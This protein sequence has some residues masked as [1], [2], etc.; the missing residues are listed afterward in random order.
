LIAPESAPKN[1][2]DKIKQLAAKLVLLPYQEVWDIVM[3]AE[4]QKS[5]GYF[6]HPGND[7]FLTEVIS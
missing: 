2:L 6:I 5:R 7:N 1:K 3:K 4:Y